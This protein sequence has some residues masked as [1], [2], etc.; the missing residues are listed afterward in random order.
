MSDLPTI[1][2]TPQE[3]YA[4]DFH[5]GEPLRPYNKAVGA[6]AATETTL[7]PGTYGLVEQADGETLRAEKWRW[8]SVHEDRYMNETETNCRVWWTSYPPDPTD[9]VEG[10]RVLLVRGVKE[11]EQ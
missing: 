4:A 11:G 2:V 10:S 8:C 1:T 6:V 7:A 5:T 3:P 9:C